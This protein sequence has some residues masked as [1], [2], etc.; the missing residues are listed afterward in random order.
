MHL[1]S[2]NLQKST[3]I[4]V[5]VYGNFTT[6][7]S[8]EI[9]VS[10]AGHTIELLRPDE[11]GKLISICVTPL[12]AV[13]RSMFPF[14]LAGSNRDYLI[15]GSDAGK[16]SILEFDVSI[17]DWK[18]LHCEVFGK[19]GCRRIV[20][21]QYIAADPKG[22]AIL[23]GAIEKQRFVY[24]MNRDSANRLTISSPLEAHKSETILFSVCGIDVGFENPIFAT[25]ELE[26]N[27]AD[28][29]PTGEAASE[30]EKK[31]T[32]YE[33]DLGLNHVVR[34][35]S[36]PISRTA[37]ILLP[38][39]GGDDGP[40]GVIICGEDWISY[41][42]QNHMEIRAPIPR[43]YDQPNTK[44]LLITTGTLHKQKDLFFYIVQSELGDLY[45]ITLDINAN[46][47][48]IVDNLYIT[49]FDSIPLSSNLCI[50][51]TGLLFASSEFN[52]HILF[53]FQGIGDN[54]TAVKSSKLEDEIN[55][56]LGDDAES[57]SSV[58]PKFKPSDKLTNLSV[59]DS[60]LSLAPI[61]DMI[62]DKSDK[63]ESYPI[64]LLSGCN[65]RS[66]L[67]TLRHG[68]PVTQLAESD[69]PGKPQAVWTIKGSQNEEYDKYIIVTFPSSTLILSIGDTIEEVTNSDF[70][71]TT[72]T[73]SVVLLDDNAMLQV[74]TYGI[75]H[76]RSDNRKSDWKTPGQ[77][78]E[79]ATIELNKEI[80]SID[81]STVPPGRIRADFLAVG[82]IDNT[83]QLLSLDPKDLL[84]QRSTMSVSNKPTSLCL[85][86]MFKE[87]VIT[88]KSQADK[89]LPLPTLYLY[90]GLVNG[91]LVRVEVEGNSGSLSDSR[92]KFLGSKSIKLS[93]IMIANYVA[94]VAL[95]SR[96]C[97]TSEVCNQG[98]VAITNQSL[99]ILTI[100]NLGFDKYLAI[101]ESDH[102]EY[103]EY[104]KQ[105]IK[106][107]VNQAFDKDKTD[108]DTDMANNDGED[109][110]ALYVPVRGPV[111]PQFGKWAS[112]IRII[113]PLNGNNKIVL[114]LSNNEAAIS[115]CT[116]K[117]TQI[118]DE[119]FLIVGIVKDLVFHPKAFT[120]SY[121]NVYRVLD[122]QLQLLH[123]T[124]VDD[125]PSVLTEFQG[126]LLVGC[127]KALRLYELGKKK[128]LRKC[129]N[130][131]FPVSIVKLQTYGDRIYVGDVAES[132]HFVKYK[133]Q[134]NSLVIFADDTVPR[135]VTCLCILDY[136]T[137]AV[138]DKFGNI[139]VLRLPDNVNDD[140]ENP[141]GP[142]MLWDQGLLNGAANKL[143]YLTSYF[144]GEI[145]T[146]I[147]K[148]SLIPGGT[149]V[150]VA[151]TIYEMFVRQE[152][153]SLCQR[154]HLSYRSC[155][156]PV[157]D[158]IDEEES[159]DEIIGHINALEPVTPDNEPIPTE[160]DTWARGIVKTRKIEIPTT[161]IYSEF[162]SDSTPRSMSSY[163]SSV[164]G[165]STKSSN[166]SKKGRLISPKSGDHTNAITQII[167]LDESFVSPKKKAGTTD[168]DIEKIKD[169]YEL[170]TDKINKISIENKG[171]PI[172]FDSSGQPIV[173]IP[174]KPEKLP[175]NSIPLGLAGIASV[176][177]ENKSNKGNNKKK[178]RIRVA[179]SRSILD[180]ET[181]FQPKHTL[182]SA[183]CDTERMPIVNPGV[184]IRNDYIKKEGPPIPEDP[185]HISRQEYLNRSINSNLSKSVNSHDY[186]INPD[187]SILDNSN[188][189]T[190]DSMD[191]ILLPE[192]MRRLYI[193]DYNL[194]E[195]SKKLSILSNNTDSYVI[196]D[197]DDKSIGPK[198][199]IGNVELS[200]L[201]GKNHS[202]DLSLKN[203]PKDRDLPYNMINVID[204]KKLPAPPLGK[205]TGHG[206]VVESKKDKKLKS[207]SLVSNKTTTS[208]LQGI[209]KKNREVVF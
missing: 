192:S 181:V 32:Y 48:K 23:I 86:F 15:I 142:R 197:E 46:N 198:D 111:P 207:N 62:V 100:D 131:L 60:L 202:I 109:D 113:D 98:I 10:R 177:N 74:H 193:D 107:A 118:S 78:V 2:L 108:Y 106:Y 123:Q 43:R 209:I 66:V 80:T 70:I 33:L 79:T 186:T 92:Q 8:Q 136:N 145:I 152:N 1:L 170:I 154:D 42:H 178:V 5:A 179:G 175:L 82:C 14:R 21:G 134:D 204:R 138:G 26:Y 76:I 12:F 91:V 149:D 105:Q 126:K 150:I 77:L 139:F 4:N 104:E 115:L 148:T 24:V 130:R 69:L 35:W 53:Q 129:E 195:G 67:R 59:T 128:L 165:H 124:D 163:R 89:P 81:I 203:R 171:K 200:K 201:P 9:V 174:V 37:N 58:A 164:T 75:R 47:K 7:K 29:D 97:F 135:Y 157:K 85:V 50:T 185:I 156:Q 151:S 125:I 72:N 103:S 93:K 190:E 49:V 73:L 160:I 159:S 188:N 25:I 176:N 17:N 116:C 183:L 110:E 117:F 16:V 41:K 133:R 208:I 19:T 122:N 168:S 143:Q 27:E 88:D 31:L 194:F 191:G 172:A 173:V 114:E 96:P 61:L 169:E 155:Y 158:T 167:E 84:S 132:I 34:K 121:I 45:K 22:R 189:L 54:P 40:S 56:Q 205:T 206:L 44:G 20:P 83:I 153:P 196:I 18:L 166:R 63:L 141:T 199:T 112:C 38:V 146:S 127:G 52:N 101:I 120:S 119:I 94:V 137:V 102:N 99:K 187:I 162:R 51:K 30:A 11:E 87:N 57:A 161:D 180:D 55:E 68:L 13:I 182:T 147:D 36:E 65:N 6:S 90:V 144:L 95:S 140:I 184:T 28:Q 39:P 3:A 64:Y 71:L